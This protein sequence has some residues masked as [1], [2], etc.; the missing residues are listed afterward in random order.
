MNWQ[1]PDYTWPPDQLIP[2]G[3]VVGFWLL[4]HME[5]VPRH[6]HGFYELALVLR[7][8]AYHVD[9]AGEQFV[10]AG[11]AIFVSPQGGHAFHSCTDML[12]YNCFFRTELMEFELIWALRDG[13]LGGLF[14]AVSSVRRDGSEPAA[15]VVP[16]DDPS[17]RACT[18]E[19]DAIRTCDPAERTHAMEVGHLLLALDLVANAVAL[20]VGSPQAQAKPPTQAVAAALELMNEDPARP[21]TL[22]DL[23]DRASVGPFRLSREFKRQ[24]GRSPMAYLNQ[25]RAER[26]ATQLAATD[27]SIA[28]VGASVGWGDPSQ[29]SR[30]FRQVFGISPRGYRARHLSA[31]RGPR[32]SSASEDE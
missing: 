14:G 4:E 22:A 24:V 10:E 17:F 9:S 25:L 11:T 19:L 12:V 28:A 32:A 20:S 3:S 30:R 8:S 16:L 13:V 5:N 6:H 1:N 15:V 18:A 29:F 23:S 2:Q 31:A 21:W 7:G 26:A 27:D